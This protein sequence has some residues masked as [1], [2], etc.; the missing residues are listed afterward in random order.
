[1]LTHDVSVTVVGPCV[2]LGRAH[3]TDED[4]GPMQQLMPTLFLWK[5]ETLGALTAGIR[6]LLF[7][8]M[9]TLVVSEIGRCVE[10]ELALNAV[11]VIA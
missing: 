8:D 7:R 3:R 4:L 11:V 2:G 6:P 9:D 1:M 5:V 10:G